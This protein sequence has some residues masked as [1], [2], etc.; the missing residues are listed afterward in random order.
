MTQKANRLLLLSAT[1][2]FVLVAVL[3]FFTKSLSLDDYDSVNLALGVKEYNLTLHQPHPPGA[4]VFIFFAKVLYA[5]G[6]SPESALTFLACLGGALFVAAWY[7]IFSLYFNRYLTFL[8]TLCLIFIPGIYM[9]ATKPMTD[10]L[11]AAFFAITLLFGSRFCKYQI[12]IDLLL[13]ALFGGLCTGIRPQ[14]GPIIL[15]VF[16]SVLF[17]TKGSAMAWLRVLSLFAFV[18]LGW[19]IPTIYSQASIPQNQ[20]GVFS[21]LDQLKVYGHQIG[22]SPEWSLSAGNLTFKRVVK[23]ILIHL[24]GCFYL[25]LGLNVWYP[26]IIN[27]T[28]SEMGTELHPWNPNIVE[29]SIAGTLYF[30]MYCIGILLYIRSSPWKSTDF[31]AFWKLNWL[32]PVAYLMMIVYSVPPANRQYFLILPILILPG[33]LGWHQLKKWRFAAILMPILILINAIPL[34]YENH[35]KLS[36]PVAMI[37]YLDKKYTLNE[38]KNIFLVLDSN[39]N[40]HAEWYLSGFNILTMGAIKKEGELLKLLKLGKVFTNNRHHFKKNSPGVILKKIKV[41]QRSLRI[42]NRHNKVILYQIIKR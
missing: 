41:F 27:K 2:V 12:N 11:A 17:I 23:Q 5:F 3:Y 13:M 38:R 30:I 15:L 26:S 40:R 18:C 16:G 32:W 20:E 31:K 9:T 24:A 37:E 35:A 28:M 34:I 29:G 36:P 21:Y 25:S 8:L 7:Y 6:I 10:S 33:I 39:V 4:P 22:Q 14:M 1:A 42:W 19:L